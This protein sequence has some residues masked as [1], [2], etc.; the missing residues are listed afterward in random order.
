MFVVWMDWEK[1][2]GEDLLLGGL[3]HFFYFGHR[4]PLKRPPLG[5]DRTG[6]KSKSNGDSRT[7][8]MGTTSPEVVLSKTKES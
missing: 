1:K 5:L 6:K 4:K 2:K 7:I 8:H 3:Y